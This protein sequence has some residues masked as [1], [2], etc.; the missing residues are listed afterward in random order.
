MGV[1]Y[2]A[3]QQNPRR[4]VALK[5]IRGERYVDAPYLRL[6]QREAQTLARLRHPCIASIYESGCTD[7]GHHF[8]AMEL[9]RGEPLDVYVKRKALGRLDRLRLFR[10]VCDAINYAHQRGV[11]HRDLKPGNV[12]V[13]A[14]GQPK[15]LDFGLARIT[16]A[17][18]AAASMVTEVGRIQGT[19]SHMSPEQAR[20]NTD[21]ID[22]RSDVYSLGVILYQLLTRR[23]PHD[24]STSAL[25]VAVRT[26]CETPPVR[27]GT[28]DRSVRGDLETIVLKAL[29]KQ[30][31]E[32]Y[33]SAAA[34]AD[35]IE[36][37]ERNQPVLARPPSAAYLLRKFVARHKAGVAVVVAMFA[38]VVGFS[39]WTLRAERHARREAEIAEYATAFLVDL[40]R[41]SDPDR[42][43]SK[44]LT[45][46][47]ILDEGAR[48]I[49]AEL[50]KT[51]AVQ[52]R[53]MSTI[54]LAYR[55]LGLYEPSMEQL[56]G[57]LEACRKAYGEDSD[58]FIESQL[59]LG[60]AARLKGDYALAERL[61]TG[62]LKVRR[63]SLGDDHRDVA[64][65][66][67]VLAAV[68]RD[69]GRF[70]L[71]EERIRESLRIWRQH[72]I[73]PENEK[74]LAVCLETLSEILEREGKY[75]GAEKH[76]IEALEIRRRLLAPDD[77]YIASSLQ[78]L[79]A[80][81]RGMG[82]YEEALKT[83]D[84]AWRIYRQ[85]MGKDHQ[86]VASVATLVGG[87]LR[88][89]GEFEKAREMLQPADEAL[90]RRFA[91]NPEHP[92]IALSSTRLG[93]LYFDLGEYPKARGL[94]E[95]AVR[96]E[97]DN[98]G[99]EHP[100]LV[101][102]LLGLGRTLYA[103][104]DLTGAEDTLRDALSVSRKS[105]PEGHWLT[106]SVRCA[107][108]QCLIALRRYDEAEAQLIAGHRDMMAI[109]GATDRYVR[110]ARH[111]LFD[112]Y[113][114]WNKPDMAAP[115]H[116]DPPGDQGRG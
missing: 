2:E 90:R 69:Q 92:Y 10:L 37:F 27:P 111:S 51:P 58:E 3:E 84:E 35:D 9:V 76:A 70:P 25:H 56:E 98:N 63:R 19:L 88:D 32:R 47:D 102:P 91:D 31:N 100:N 73:D 14:D 41:T 110:A 8:F 79:A 59:Q 66:L 86:Y 94:F 48:R 75:R 39:L 7:D 74:Q 15:V 81:Q 72:S 49:K 103:V 42:A 52:G 53:L 55:N 38:V 60:A 18:V 77:H 96:I 16:D 36:R 23:L 89:L 61:V 33:Q 109:R 80:A 45:A 64:R 24:F 22:L 71:A 20:G 106:G 87:I 12:L 78:A 101:S 50:N 26:L 44:E 113:T 28:I 82:R 85:A 30:P 57:A 107:L 6:F 11:I 62:V 54:G 65:T 93:W 46:R 105:L 5:V 4:A 116:I 83:A 99:D 13:T 68:Y 34:L 40:F 97:R 1:V 17:D 95:E 108:G 43:G 104:G 112:L 67:D 21:E 114:K 115:Y 29:A